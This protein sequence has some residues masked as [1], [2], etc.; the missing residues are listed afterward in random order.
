MTTV[1]LFIY[2]AGLPVLWYHKY[3]T[4]LDA[5]EKPG[6]YNSPRLYVVFSAAR[7]ILAW[8]SIAA[9]WMLIGPIPGLAAGVL[10]FLIGALALRLYY[11]RQVAK[12]LAVFTKQIAKESSLSPDVPLLPEL[13]RDALA[14]ARSQVNKAMKGQLT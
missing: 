4:V 10:Y 9:I 8:G 3:C 13:A 7:L 12:W 2:A 11:E 1:A 14:L 5:F 6:L